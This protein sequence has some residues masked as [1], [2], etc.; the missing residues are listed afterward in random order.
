MASTTA[1]SIWRAPHKMSSRLL[2]SNTLLRQGTSQK[3]QRGR[4]CPT[5]SAFLLTAP[6]KGCSVQLQHT[7]KEMV[8]V[9]SNWDKKGQT[10]TPTLCSGTGPQLS[11]F[12]RSKRYMV[13]KH[14]FIS[15]QQR[16]SHWPSVSLH[17]LAV[18]R[19]AEMKQKPAPELHSPSWASW[20]T[21]RGTAQ[22]KPW[23]RSP[24]SLR[25]SN[26][27]LISLGIYN[28]AAHNFNSRASS[29]N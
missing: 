12:K 14:N 10:A 3:K 18:R 15:H 24:S 9:L 7:E 27:E 4:A 11:A 19:W 25:A 21:A 2:F 22:E 16:L 17:L 8:P 26:S 13:L 6:S 23:A 28:K 29:I 5:G 1:Y 20:P